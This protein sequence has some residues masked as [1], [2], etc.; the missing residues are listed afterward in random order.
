MSVKLSM[1]PLDLVGRV[2]D[3]A[4]SPGFSPQTPVV[5]Q[6]KST[7]PLAKFRVGLSIPLGRRT[8]PLNRSRRRRFRMDPSLAGLRWRRSIISL[9]PESWR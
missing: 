4:E 9:S 8:I 7:G 1:R 3:S 2:Q 6:F 5:G